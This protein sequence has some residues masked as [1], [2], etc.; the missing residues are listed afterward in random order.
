[1]VEVIA[2]FFAEI[3]AGGVAGTTE[4][5]RARLRK[6]MPRDQVRGKCSVAY[7]A[8]DCV[9][10]D[11]ADFVAGAKKQT[12]GI[13]DFLAGILACVAGIRARRFAACTDGIREM[14]VGV[15]EIGCA[16]TYG[17]ASD[18]FHG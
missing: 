3:L 18:S 1:M 10:G 13:A 7:L 8:V 16:R 14:R 9:T 2:D 11:V 5:G 4:G 15:S 6:V 12:S 17:H